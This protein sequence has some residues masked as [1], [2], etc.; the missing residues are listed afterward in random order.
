VAFGD[1]GGSGGGW[2]GLSWSGLAVDQNRH[3]GLSGV[4]TRNPWPIERDGI[5]AVVVYFG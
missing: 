2:L 4:Q 5:P 3:A 1:A